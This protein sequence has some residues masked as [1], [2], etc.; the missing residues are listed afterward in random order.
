MPDGRQ[1]VVIV[2]VCPKGTDVAR[3][4]IA[5]EFFKFAGLK[6]GF[7]KIRKTRNS[8]AGIG[9][10]GAEASHSPSRTFSCCPKLLQIVKYFKEDFKKEKQKNYEKLETL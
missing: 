8:W 4:K 1:P 2:G 7:M 9:S 3:R 6:P 5:I 10:E